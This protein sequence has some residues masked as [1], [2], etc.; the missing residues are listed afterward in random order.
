M[1]PIPPSQDLYEA[2]T[3]FRQLRLADISSTESDE[4][5]QEI[6][7][8]KQFEFHTDSL[9]GLVVVNITELLVLEKDRASLA[10]TGQVME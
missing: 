1:V 3:K 10:A 7:G 6:G 5:Y 8:R 4:V 9:Y 2:V